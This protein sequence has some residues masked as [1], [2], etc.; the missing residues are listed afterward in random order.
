VVYY[1]VDIIFNDVKEG[2]KPGMTADIVI[3]AEKKEN[4]LVIPRGAMKKRDSE[5]IVKVFS[6][7]NIV[8]KQ[9]KTGLEG[10]DFV[11]VISG[12]KEG[13]QVVID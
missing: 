11:E 8:E 6:G 3:E 13:D 1:Q 9:I 2:I 10:D 7:K 12:L 4:V 5:R